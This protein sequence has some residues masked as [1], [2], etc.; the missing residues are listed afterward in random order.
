MV[1]DEQ[2]QQWAPR[3][4]YGRANNPNDREKDWL[5]E[6]KPGDDPNVDPFETKAEARRERLNKQKR[7]EERNRLEAAHAAGL[8]SRGAGAGMGKVS[9]LSSASDRKS[10][11]NQAIAATQLSTASVGRFD[12]R[13]EHEPSKG[14]GKRQQYA[15]ATDQQHLKADKERAT[16]VVSR[17]FPEGAMAKSAAISA[18]KAEKVARLAEESS[19]RQK[20]LAKN[21]AKTKK[22]APSKAAP[23]KAAKPSLGAKASAKGGRKPGAG[24]KKGK[25]K[26]S[27]KRGKK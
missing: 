21:A 26:T 15:S 13:L 19:N 12:K 14:R 10:Y 24:V 4:G 16:S 9:G 20:K 2:M 18:D 3:Y 22:V 5:V 6:V 11:L 25:P 1:W 17:M 27:I 7:Q 23:S 8:T